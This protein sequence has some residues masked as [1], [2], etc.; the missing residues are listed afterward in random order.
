MIWRILSPVAS[1]RLVSPPPSSSTPP[2][3]SR[4]RSAPTRPLSL[5]R[6][7]C[8]TA[9]TRS[10]GRWRTI[11]WM[12]YWRCWSKARDTK[13]AAPVGAALFGS[14]HPRMRR[15]KLFGQSRR[16]LRPTGARETQAN[17]AKLRPRI[18]RDAGSTLPDWDHR[19]LRCWRCHYR[20]GPPDRSRWFRSVNTPE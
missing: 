19:Q 2:Q 10:C 12:R 16:G 13:R 1:P 3:R 4:R 11:I 20:S 15:C 14:E 7:P 18:A 9:R 6:I 5:C 8:R 17:Q